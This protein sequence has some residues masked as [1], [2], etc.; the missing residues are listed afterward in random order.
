MNVNGLTAENMCTITMKYI[1]ITFST[2]VPLS[3]N[4]RNARVICGSCSAIMRRWSIQKLVQTTC[5][6]TLLVYVLLWLK[7]IALDLGLL[8]PW[9]LIKCLVLQENRFGKTQAGAG[10]DDNYG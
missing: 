5:D 7:G 2:T 8:V 4:V 1:N 3:Y 9:L 10:Q 6:V